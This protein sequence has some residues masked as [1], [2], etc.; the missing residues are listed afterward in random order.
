M[1][2]EAVPACVQIKILRRFRAESSRHLHAIDP[3]HWLIS[4][5]VPAPTAA[6]APAIKGK[7]DAVDALPVLSPNTSTKKDGSQA[8]E[9]YRNTFDAAWAAASAH[10][11]SDAR[12][13][14]G[15]VRG[16]C[17]TGAAASLAPA[18]ASHTNAN[19]A[20]PPPHA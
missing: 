17:S 2:S 10:T 11:G 4:T 16:S 13:R 15:S 20:P 9:K 14:Q 5:Q 7:S 3:T 8:T 19:N 12:R 18:V 6:I 1:A